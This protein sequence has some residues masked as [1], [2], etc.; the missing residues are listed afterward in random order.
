MKAFSDERILQA[1]RPYGAQPSAEKCGQIRWY[2]EKLL[3]WNR[4]V[5]L[6]SITEPGEIL[7]RHFGESF[8]SA[9]FLPSQ[10]TLIDIGSGAG[11]P[12]LA[13]KIAC[14]DL[15]VFLVEPNKKKSTFLNEVCRGID[16]Q[17]VRVLAQE[18][19]EI[20]NE[21]SSVNIVT[22][23]A[24][25][26]HGELLEWSIRVGARTAAFW[27]GAKGAAEISTDARFSWEKLLIPGNKESFLVIGNRI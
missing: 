25:G 20:T 14:P 11:F 6:T 23:R 9:Q 21:I 5:N 24:V 10:G 12:G 7:R 2:A 22:A 27:V 3:L 18:F 16:L 17:G 1:L 8:F 15:S 13:L 4:K 19:Q 26:S